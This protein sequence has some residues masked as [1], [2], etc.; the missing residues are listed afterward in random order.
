[1]DSDSNENKRNA[2]NINSP[3]KKQKTDD[4]IDDDNNSVDSLENEYIGSDLT[5]KELAVK[6]LRKKIRHSKSKDKN[7]IL[8]KFDKEIRKIKRIHYN[9]DYLNLNIYVKK[10]I[11][12]QVIEYD[13]LYEEFKN[14]K[15]EMGNNEKI[16]K[17]LE[18][19]MRKDNKKSNNYI[20]IIDIENMSS[21]SP[22]GMLLK[23]LNNTNNNINGNSGNSKLI[24]EFDELL[25]SD[26]TRLTTSEYM[27]KLKKDKIKYYF[28]KLKEVKNEN[29]ENTNTN[30]NINTNINIPNILK[31]LEWNISQN[32]KEIIINKLAIYESMRGSSE[33]YKLKNWIN[34][35]MKIPFNNYIK[36]P[37]SIEDE[38]EKIINYLQE[39]RNNFN[40]EIYGHEQAKDQLIKIIGHTITNPK[41]GG[42]VFGL[43]GPP[44]V[45]K[46][47]LVLSGIGKALGRPVCFI[48][49]GGATDASYLE[50]HDYTYEGSLPG[51][52]VDVL[53]NAR[54]MNPIIFFDELDKV[55]ETAKGEE[56]INILMHITD[57]TQNNKFNDKYFSGIEIDL[58]KAII[59]FSFN[60]EQKISRILKDRMKIIRVKGYKLEEKV[61]ILRDYI[62]PKLRKSI[63]LG[64]EVEISD[65][66]IRYMIENYTFEGGVRKIKE[67]IN[68][69]YMEINIRY[70]ENKIKE[71]KENKENKVIITI[72]D[73][74][75]DY[76]RNKHK[77]IMKEINNKS[78]IGL[79]NGLWAND[80]GVGGITP[81]ECIWIPSNH[82]LDLKLTGMQGKV[83]R[84]SME[85]AKTVAWKLIDSET[86]IKL[87]EKW[88]KTK[89]YGIHIHCPDGATNKDGPSA[90][91]AI[92]VA[93][94]SLLTGREINNE[95]AMTGEINL[96]GEI[97]IIG[98]LDAKICGA[99]K[100][101]VKRI[102]CPYENKRDVEEIKEKYKEM[103]KDI[104]IIL[105][106]NIEEVIKIIFN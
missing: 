40:K 33:V 89:E 12:N 77:I 84:E 55:S 9:S 26:S 30:T 99:Y 16:E 54:C 101:G 86:K 41:E 27:R 106:K 35:V 71:N 4:Y 64:V 70:L 23:S 100:A 94:Y 5:P 6:M 32:N 14:S 67:I 83:M 61:K 17:Y 53:S 76:L 20:E 96:K 65:D 56:I 93:I 74:D 1:M 62:M 46:T 2:L 72:E 22:L 88:K 45:G 37:I 52:I 42:S 63:N 73:I 58:S 60:N 91:G 31:V 82:K 68:D 11:E 51:K 21:L 59:I 66:I 25:N 105:V 50:G 98:G 102:L 103:V 18:E 79:I 81:I 39:T 49:L 43:Q 95:I 80:Y 90:G 92:T 19:Y 69:I 78:K 44:G 13:K 75:D 38:R 7:E 24:K 104:E 3:N 87:N 28:D 10:D 36:T 34:R 97:T 85:V 15:I 47:E 48:G 57:Q 29:K 8:E